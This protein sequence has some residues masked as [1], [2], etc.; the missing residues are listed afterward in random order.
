MLNRQSQP[1]IYLIKENK[2][3]RRN[4][5]LLLTQVKSKDRMSTLQIKHY[6][7]ATVLFDEKYYLQIGSSLST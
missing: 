7:A 2:R 5:Q 1:S 3:L 4:V 6:Y